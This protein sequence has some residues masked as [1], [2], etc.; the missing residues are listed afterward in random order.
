MF[1]S[2]EDYTP[3]LPLVISGAWEPLSL[4]TVYTSLLFE[5]TQVT[6]VICEKMHKKEC[7]F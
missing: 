5:D 2:L 7:S 4:F 3:N 1:Q 6:L